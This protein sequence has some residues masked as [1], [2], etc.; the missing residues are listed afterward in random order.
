LKNRFTGLTKTNLALL[1]LA[2]VPL[3]FGLLNKPTKMGLSIGVGVIALVFLN[4]E[5]ISSAKIGTIE[6]KMNEVRSAVGNLFEMQVE[7]SVT[8]VAA[9]QLRYINIAL[10]AWTGSDAKFN[11]PEMRRKLIEFGNENGVLKLEVVNQLKFMADR[12]RGTPVAVRKR[13]DN[14][15]RVLREIERT[16]SS[17]TNKTNAKEL[18]VVLERIACE[19][20]DI[21]PDSPL[22]R[23]NA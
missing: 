7:K 12:A 18:T 1:Y 10:N 9:A 8:D 21:S 2:V 17:T 4:L 23:E 16:G 14:L 3:A 19:L 13:E 11:Y 20:R 15:D 6:L 22:N 5:E